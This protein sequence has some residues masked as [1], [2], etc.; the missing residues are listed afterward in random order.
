[1]SHAKRTHAIVIILTFVAIALPFYVS[2][3]LGESAFHELRY[4]RFLSREFWYQKFG[5]GGPGQTRIDE[6]KIVAI[7]R[8]VQPGSILG[9][10][11]CTHREFMATL[12]TRVAQYDPRLIVVDK[13]YNH[14]PPGVCTG[15]KD[16]TADLKNAIRTISA[17]TPLVIGVESFSR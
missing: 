4:L 1:M 13:W 16:G 9:E 3:F 15:P 10:N 8:A 11:R 2:E 6:F 14:I 5:P 7:D 12:L 17:K